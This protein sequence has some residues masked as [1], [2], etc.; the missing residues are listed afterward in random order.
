MKPLELDDG[1]L[2]CI[3]FDR[4]VF[5]MSTVWLADPELRYLINAENMSQPQR[6]AWFEALTNR[7]DYIIQ[8]M[9]LDGT[10]VG[11]FG[12]KHIDRINHRAEYWLYLGSRAYWGLG[13]G[14]AMLKEGCFIA[15]ENDVTVLYVHIVSDNDRSKKFFQRAGFQHVRDVPNGVEMHTAVASL[16]DRLSH[17]GRHAR[18]DPG[19]ER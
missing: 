13:I 7:S 11:C 15:Q 6:V 4:R 16:L 17:D 10:P 18:T 12:I 3:P 5:D 19:A 14:R 8:A 2:T 1:V 9:A